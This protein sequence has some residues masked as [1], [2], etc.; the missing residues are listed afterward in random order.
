[1]DARPVGRHDAQQAV[2]VGVAQLQVPDGQVILDGGVLRE[3]AH[4]LE[5]DPRLI[6]AGGADRDHRARRRQEVMHTD[7]RGQ[8]GLRVAAGEDRRDLARPA[9]VRAGDALLV[10]RERLADEVA[11]LDQAS[12]SGPN[13]GS[14]LHNQYHTAVRCLGFSW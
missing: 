9:E 6:A 2:A 10:R 5:A 14:C 8:R 11:E 7:L 3:A 1:V 4:P 13:T 12:Q